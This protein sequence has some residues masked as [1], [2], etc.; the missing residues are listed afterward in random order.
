MIP[1][2]IN[3]SRGFGQGNSGAATVEFALVS[4]VFFTV[5]FGIIEGGRLIYDYNRVSF[6]ARDGARWAAVHASASED[7]EKTIAEIQA[8]VS[9]R[10]FGLVPATDLG[11]D[12]ASDE[13]VAVQTI[14]VKDGTVADWP[15]NN[16][17]DNLVRV[18]ASAIFSPI[19]GLVPIGQLTLRST[20]TMLIH[21]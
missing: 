7:R 14:I 9:D 16:A 21:R 8:Y 15:A 2:N 6:A 4:I 20:A 19:V 1:S 18:T 3:A 17:P 10:S 13:G 11:L 12:D 5:L